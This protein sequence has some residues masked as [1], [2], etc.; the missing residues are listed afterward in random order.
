MFLLLA[1][2]RRLAERHAGKLSNYSK[3]WEMVKIKHQIPN[4]KHQITTLPRRHV[5]AIPKS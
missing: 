5:G 2:L 1:H 3:R 4:H